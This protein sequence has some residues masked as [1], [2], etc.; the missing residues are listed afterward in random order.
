[1]D[2]P[3]K[4]EGPKGFEDRS[5][6][7]LLQS[8]QK[9]DDAA[10]ERLFHHYLPRLKR[11]TQ[12]RLPPRARDLVDTEDLVQETFIRTVRNLKGF[13]YRH[14]GAF[15]GYLRSALKNRIRDEVRRAQRTP[16]ATTADPNRPSPDV[17]PLELAL[18]KEALERY[19]RALGNL[20]PEEREAIVSRIELGMSYAEVAEVL[21]K[22]SPDA[23][24]MAVSR[25][26]LRL[27]QRMRQ[28]K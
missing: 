23:A 18:G 3:D 6:F 21:G 11:W 2:L 22:A 26:I 10:L 27:A 15:Q 14:E 7:L 12:G 19:E 16:D 8:A 5:S 28:E 9:G 24:R 4:G 17:S 1:M 13:E 25:A 20:K